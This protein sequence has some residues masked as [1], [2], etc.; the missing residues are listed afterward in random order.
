MITYLK[1]VSKYIEEYINFYKNNALTDTHHLRIKNYLSNNDFDS[2]SRLLENP[3][4]IGVD[5]AADMITYVLTSRLS[6]SFVN[7]DDNVSLVDGVKYYFKVINFLLK[8][9]IL[10]PNTGIDQETVNQV[11]Y[12]EEHKKHR[13]YLSQHMLLNYYCIV[14]KPEEIKSTLDKILNR[15]LDKISV[16]KVRGNE[17][18]ANSTADDIKQKFITYLSNANS[19]DDKLVDFFCGKYS[20]AYVLKNLGLATELFTYIA[21]IRENI[22]FVIPLLLHQKLFHSFKNIG[23][24][25]SYGDSW[26][27]PT[28]FLVLSK[29]RAF[30][31]ELGRGKPEMISHLASVS[32][33]ATGFIDVQLNTENKLGYKCPICS[34]AFTICKEYQRLFLDFD[35]EVIM[36]TDC[37]SCEYSESCDDKILECSKHK[38]NIQTQTIR[39][40][41]H[42]KCWKGLSPREKGNLQVLR[43]NIPSY[44]I[45]IGL[46]KIKKGFC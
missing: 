1:H 28:D 20:P 31:I 8:S 5:D 41:C 46:D 24:R 2:I 6:H 3:K 37:P 9:N 7:N 43:K 35:I 42:E 19:I 39:F 17:D 32:G 22:G 38:D 15:Q 4:Q 30:A 44:P 29:G 13:S 40:H 23:D 45:V 26:V 18:F 10:Y 34:N 11:F 16:L 25:D 27:A 12:Q 33:I 36:P 21:L 14:T